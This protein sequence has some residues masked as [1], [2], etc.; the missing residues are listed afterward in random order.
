MYGE[1]GE[2]MG[3]GT[4]KNDGKLAIKFP[5]NKDLIVA[6]PLGNLSR[7]PPPPLPGGY[8]LGEKLYYIGPTK[9]WDDGD[10]LDLLPGMQGEVIGPCGEGLVVR[11]QHES[12]N[13]DVK[14]SKCL[15]EEL[16][17][18][19]PS[20]AQMKRALQLEKKKVARNAEGKGSV[21]SVTNA[22]KA[23]RAKNLSRDEEDKLFKETFGE[24]MTSHP[25]WKTCSREQ[26]E[27]LLA[28]YVS[29]AEQGVRDA[30][31]EDIEVAE[32][33]RATVLAFQEEHKA[34]WEA[35]R[36]KEAKEEDEIKAKLRELNGKSEGTE[37]DPQLKVIL[38]KKFIA[39][40]K[41][42][43]F[44]SR[45]EQKEFIATFLRLQ[46]HMRSKYEAD[47]PEYT[48]L[49]GEDKPQLPSNGRTTRWAAILSERRSISSD[50][51][52]RSIMATVVLPSTATAPCTASKAR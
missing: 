41:E 30:V 8:T 42:K 20:R 19:P 43:G 3:S 29:T 35:E 34:E 15:L 45:E 33:V 24:A 18:S 1:Q 26:Q 48:R 52:R 10:R 17:R 44:S 23:L 36:L 12:F 27:Y 46:Q 14:C 49:K 50:Q 38:R 13:G 22:L 37:M 51:A 5:N 39:M 6:C 16:S 28:E 7:S 40:M 32:Q 31:G 11:F 21:V 25:H 2:V 4:G 47:H 9:P